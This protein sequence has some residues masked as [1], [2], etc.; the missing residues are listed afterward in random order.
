MFLT[1]RPQTNETNIAHQNL[2]AH[3]AFAVDGFPMRQALVEPKCVTA[4]ATA[5][6]DD[7]PH[8]L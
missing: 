7:V 5:R 1:S 8:F 3:P 4:D 2:I 6:D